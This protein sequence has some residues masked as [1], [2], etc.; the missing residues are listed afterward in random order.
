MRQSL[1]PFMILFAAMLWGTAGT[2]KA[3]ASEVDS[4]SMGVARLVIGGVMLM[5]IAVLTKKM[6]FKGWP[7]KPLIIGGI[8]MA[9][10]QPFFFSAVELTGIAVGTVVSI[11]SAPVFSGMIE[12]LIF[13]IRPS[14]V[15]WLSTVLA[16]TGCI[17]LMFNTNAVTV[18][19]SG[20]LRGLGAGI[21]FASFTMSNSRLVQSRDPIASVAMIFCLSALILSPFLFIN[22]MSWIGE[23]NGLLVA[24][25]IGLFATTLAYFLFSS[26]LRH[27]K[28]STA[29]TL[30]LAEPLTASLL[31]VFL[32]GETLDSLSWAGLI[33]LLLGIVILV[34]QSRK[35]KRQAV[36][37]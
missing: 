36:N 37:V 2:A 8:A 18:D 24:L 19:A 6:T 34:L 35:N 20:V 11:G 14:R 23:T 27:V 25:H 33:M 28:S 31:G 7:V 5:A 3:F 30:S 29:V 12:W 22:D 21:S 32:V 15:W 1:A 10:F 16:I 4:I 13:K 26:G 17:I 9:L